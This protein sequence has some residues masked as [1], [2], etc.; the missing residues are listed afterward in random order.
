MKSS[1]YSLILIML[2]GHCSNP[3]VSLD[4]FI[5]NFYESNL[6]NTL[7][8]QSEDEIKPYLSKSLRVLFDQ[9][10]KQQENF[11][12]EHPD[13]KPALVDTLLFRSMPFSETSKV[14]I[15]EIKKIDNI[16]YRVTVSFNSILTN[17]RCTDKLFIQRNDT[18]YEI[19][20]I[21]LGCY[22]SYKLSTLLSKF[23]KDNQK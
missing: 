5:N 6:P 2:L 18:S 9:A 4:M 15:E 8:I 17:K 12:Q 21:E 1:I 13:L 20:D 7:G 16:I 22:N 11:T 10:R 14:I 3:S 19:M 23:I